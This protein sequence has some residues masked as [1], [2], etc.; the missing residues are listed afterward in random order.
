MQYIED[1]DSIHT[2]TCTPIIHVY[3]YIHMY[4]DE[5]LEDNT[6]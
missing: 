6:P 2:D 4:I 5:L 1:T 3:Y